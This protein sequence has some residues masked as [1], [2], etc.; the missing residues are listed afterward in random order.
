M[1]SSDASCTVAFVSAA[2]IH[3]CQEDANC[4]LDPAKRK[5]ASCC[6]QQRC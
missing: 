2:L 5:G 6:E 4:D 1:S 3:S